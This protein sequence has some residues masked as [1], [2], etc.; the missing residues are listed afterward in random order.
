MFL[1]EAA[2][3]KVARDLPQPEHWFIP[4]FRWLF[5]AWLIHRSTLSDLTNQDILKN[6]EVQRLDWKFYECQSLKIIISYLLCTMKC[7]WN[8]S[9]NGF[10]SS[11]H[12]KHFGIY[13]KIKIA[14]INL[15]QWKKL[16]VDNIIV[17]QG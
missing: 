16:M 5:N 17:R 13:L 12:V 8:N 9:I 15:K 10:F 1:W 14:S 3:K 4:Q 6:G 7:L 11:C 2:H